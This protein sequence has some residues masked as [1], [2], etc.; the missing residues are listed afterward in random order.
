MRYAGARGQLT[1]RADSGFY[2]HALVAVCRKMDVRFSITIRQH[3]SLRNLIEAIPEGDWTPIPSIYLPFQSAPDAAPVR[4]IVR[5]V[6]PT[7]GSQLA[8]FATYSYHGCITDRD[9]ETLELEADHRR[10]AE[11]ENAIRDLK[12]GVGLNH[13]LSGRFAANGAWLAVQSLPRTRYGVLAHNLARWTVRLGLGEQIVTT[14]T[15]RRRF[16]SMSGR[17]TRSARRLTLH[18]P[19]R[20]PWENQFSGALARLRALPFPA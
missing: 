15:L 6:K 12:Y 14:K 9:G 5:R 17:L 20:W 1:V 10:H 18:L 7:P 11:I 8:L 4:L 16:F 13:L 2:T 19:Q 3:K